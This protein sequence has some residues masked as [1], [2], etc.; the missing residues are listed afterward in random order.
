MCESI[1]KSIVF[2]FFYNG[3]EYKNVNSGYGVEDAIDNE[4]IHDYDGPG[5]CWNLAMIYLISKSLV[6]RKPVS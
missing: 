6:M 5:L 1:V 4:Y 3:Q 2:D